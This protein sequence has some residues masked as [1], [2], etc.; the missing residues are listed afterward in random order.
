M[1]ATNSTAMS[2]LMSLSII[3]SRYPAMRLRNCAFLSWAIKGSDRPDVRGPALCERDVEKKD[4]SQ[5]HANDRDQKADA[6]AL[7]LPQK[8][9]GQT[10]TRQLQLV[11]VI[12]RLGDVFEI[13]GREISSNEE[14]LGAA[15]GITRNEHH[16]QKE[17]DDQERQQHELDRE[18]TRKGRIIPENRAHHER[19]EKKGN[20][21]LEVARPDGLGVS[22]D[23]TAIGLNWRGKGFVQLT[24]DCSPL[25]ERE[26]SLKAFLL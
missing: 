24:I 11:D 2:A 22:G 10:R 21:R 19:D 18:V 8:N 6:N 4:H 9:V 14:T 13:L 12:D 15:L 7:R 23:Q 1:I 26:K 17:I 5:D 25:P 20:V 16:E 3:E